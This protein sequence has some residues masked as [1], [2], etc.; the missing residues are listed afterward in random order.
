[1]LSDKGSKLFSQNLSHQR[2]KEGL[3]YLCRDGSAIVS[4]EIRGDLTAGMNELS[5][6]WYKAGGSLAVNA[7]RRGTGTT[8]TCLSTVCIRRFALGRRSFEVTSFSTARTTP[9]LTRRP[10][11]VLRTLECS[12]TQMVE[13]TRHCRRLCRHI[14]LGRVGRPVGISAGAMLGSVRARRRC[15]RDHSLYQWT[16]TR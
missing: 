10:I 6:I 1:M 9:S 7:D 3:G 13:D 11:A 16:S 2:G 14:R 4:T 5:A 12:Q 8:P 15:C